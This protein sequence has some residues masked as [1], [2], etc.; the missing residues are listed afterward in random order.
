MRAA[1]RLTHRASRDGRGVVSKKVRFDLGQDEFENEDDCE[2]ED[3]DRFAENE[4]D[5]S[6]QST[7]PATHR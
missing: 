2:N 1:E 4:D 6:L 5:F 3:E 7:P